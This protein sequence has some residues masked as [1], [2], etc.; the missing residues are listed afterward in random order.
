LVVTNSHSKR[1]GNTRT[2]DGR[3]LDAVNLDTI[4][5]VEN[6]ESTISEKSEDLGSILALKAELAKSGVEGDDVG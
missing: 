3:K 4:S 2:A 1:R 6:A 5:G